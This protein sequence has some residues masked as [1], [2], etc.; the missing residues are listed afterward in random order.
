MQIPQR[1]GLERSRLALPN[2]RHPKLGQPRQQG[3]GLRDRKVGYDRP[4]PV[5]GAGVPEATAHLVAS[6]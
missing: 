6:G 4:T 2:G 5:R 1:H 3:R